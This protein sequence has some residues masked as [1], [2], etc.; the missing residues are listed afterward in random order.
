MA[1]KKKGL[2]TQIF[3]RL[4][5]N[6]TREVNTK[7]KQDFF[8]GYFRVFQLGHIL[9]I[10]FTQLFLHLETDVRL[11]MFGSANLTSFTQEGWW[12]M[13]SVCLQK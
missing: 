11:L 6:E 2:Q 1:K 9:Y 7:R 3:V 13:S 10:L 12:Q 8:S 4:V 5:K